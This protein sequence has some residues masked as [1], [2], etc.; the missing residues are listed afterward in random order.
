MTEL[1]EHARRNREHWDDMAAD[2]VEPGRRNWS[3]AEP[4]WGIRDRDFVIAQQARRWPS[5][6]VIKAVK[7]S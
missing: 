1:P 4:T 5:E 6:H 7:R 2:W 3:A